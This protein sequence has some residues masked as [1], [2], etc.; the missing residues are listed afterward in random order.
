MKPSVYKRRKRLVTTSSTIHL[1]PKL[2][3]HFS[4][5]RLM[6]SLGSPVCRAPRSVRVSRESQSQEYDSSICLCRPRVLPARFI[7]KLSWPHRLD[8]VTRCSERLVAWWDAPKKSAGGLG[9]QK[10]VYTEAWKVTHKTEPR[11]VWGDRKT[12]LL[13]S[14]FAGREFLG[15][16]CE[17]IPE[18]SGFNLNQIFQGVFSSSGPT[19]RCRLQTSG[20]KVQGQCGASL[21]FGAGRLRDNVRALK[22]HKRKC[23]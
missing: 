10:L 6:L 17:S 4:E 1:I 8:H 20:G 21:S 7:I 14:R 23:V 15:K 18:L 9:T 5:V 22:A 3:C 19:D 13:A 12:G 11:R 2:F 16:K